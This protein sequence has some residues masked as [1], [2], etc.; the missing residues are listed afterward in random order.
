MK[1]V[2]YVMIAISFLV[3]M[4][5]RSF[6]IIRLPGAVAIV[7]TVTHGIQKDFVPSTEKLMMTQQAFYQLK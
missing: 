6:S 1:H 3:M 4:D 2:F 7:E 5:M